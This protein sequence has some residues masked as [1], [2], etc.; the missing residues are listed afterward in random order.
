MNTYQSTAVN[1]IFLCMQCFSSIILTISFLLKLLSLCGFR[2]LSLLLLQIKFP[3][4]F[5][6][7]EKAENAYRLNVRASVSPSACVCACVCASACTRHMSLP[8]HTC[9]LALHV[10]VCVCALKY[11]QS[12]ARS[13]SVPGLSQDSCIV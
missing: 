2:A 9:W 7:F 4:W 1:Q 12:C 11:A 13:S 3:Q 6:S 10:H 8:M 5:V